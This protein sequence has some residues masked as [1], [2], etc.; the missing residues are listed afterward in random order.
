[1]NNHYHHRRIRVPCLLRNPERLANI[2]YL[3]FNSYSQG[4]CWWL[5]CLI[6]KNWTS[7]IIKSFEFLTLIRYQKQYFQKLKQLSSKLF[8][9]LLALFQFSS[10]NLEVLWPIRITPTYCGFEWSHYRILF[11]KL[12]SSRRKF[13]VTSFGQLYEK[14]VAQLWL[15]DWL[16]HRL[17]Q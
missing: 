11:P 16:S 4:F 7:I 8:K 9:Y 14:L 10:Q 12:R 2:K 3:H 13:K 17:P 5:K 1:M 6:K 15:P